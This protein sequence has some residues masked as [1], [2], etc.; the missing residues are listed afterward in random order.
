MR[1][2]E[3]AKVCNTKISVLRHYDKNGVLMPEYVDK[4]TGYR[5]YTSEQISVFFRITALKKAGF[6]LSEIKNMLDKFKSDEEILC[7]FEN[8]R[9][10]LIKTLSD[11]DEAK[12]IILGEEQMYKVSFINDNGALKAVTSK[13]DS[14]NQNEARENLAKEILKNGYQRVS[15][16]CTNGELFNNDVYISCEVIKLKKTPIKLNDNIDLPFENDERVIGKWE[17]VGE[18]TLKED[19]YGDVDHRATA[20]KTI[21]FLPDGERYWCYG[22]TKGKLLCRSGDG[23]TVNDYTLEE[24]DGETYMFVSYKS[25][26][27]RFGGNPSVL[28]LRK[29]DGNSYSKEDLAV[30]DDIH[31]PFV[32]DPSV[33]GK[34]KACGFCRTVEA[35]DPKDI[36]GD[37]H[38]FSNIEF[39]RGGAVTSRYN[40]GE[41]V[42]S[43]DD[44][45]VWTKGYV[46]RKFNSTACEYVL[47]EIDGTEYLFIQWKSGDYVYG[48][49]EPNYYVFKRE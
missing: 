29:I 24:Y 31:M 33:I 40:Y 16:F 5:Y 26:E 11:L 9:E 2:G 47:K 44:T 39:F 14:N 28:V 15:C 8:K 46:L 48:R 19:F 37:T 34:W 30:K 41:T 45:Q 17:A 22:W 18:Y 7:L 27:Y 20:M 3:F 25:G 23:S 13:F 32:D 4:F 38:F 6:S 10:S 21:Y 43:G 1:I 42:L 36:K 12:R 35:F 49:L